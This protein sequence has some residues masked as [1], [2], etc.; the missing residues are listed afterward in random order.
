MIT[1][2]SPSSSSSIFEIYASKRE[3]AIVFSDCL[4]GPLIDL[5]SFKALK[6]SSFATRFEESIFGSN[7]GLPVVPISNTGAVL[8]RSLCYFNISSYGNLRFEVVPELA[9]NDYG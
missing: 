4:V 3:R 5:T 6:Y 9:A 1:S 7:F 8:G 2:S